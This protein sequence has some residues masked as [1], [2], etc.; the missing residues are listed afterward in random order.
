LAAAVNP[1]ISERSVDLRKE[2]ALA[3][4]SGKDIPRD[5]PA[6]VQRLAVEGMPDS[7]ARIEQTGVA[8]RVSVY[9][10]GNSTPLY[11]N[12]GSVRVGGPDARAAI[13]A[14]QQRPLTSI[15][16]GQAAEEADAIERLSSR[17]D[18][19]ASAEEL[20]RYEVLRAEA[21]SQVRADPVAHAEY[22]E[23]W[24]RRVTECHQALTESRQARDHDPAARERFG[25]KSHEME[26]YVKDAARDKILPDHIPDDSVAKDV[27]DRVT[28]RE[29]QV[30]GGSPAR[31]TP[32]LQ[33]G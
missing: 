9:Q 17:P 14:E 28:R 8:D 20:T 12:E 1:R 6:S 32:E 31:A 30:H 16:K 18:S 22:G 4:V 33:P 23:R 21:H 26:Q 27:R 13:R 19:H 10:R 15:E 7:I 3:D 24:G 5:V 2:R 29:A 11:V 25:E